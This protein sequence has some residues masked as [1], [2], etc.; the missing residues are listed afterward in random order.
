MK[1]IIFISICLLFSSCVKQM[2]LEKSK[3]EKRIDG[4]YE[5]RENMV[6]DVMNNHLKK[7]MGYNSVIELLGEPGNYMNIKENEIIYE[8]M[9]DYKWNIDPMEGTELYI[10]FGKDSTLINYRLEHW[11]H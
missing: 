5:Y 8:I 11:E 3:W 4:F 10:E 9:V 1:K 2:E 7:G 6:K